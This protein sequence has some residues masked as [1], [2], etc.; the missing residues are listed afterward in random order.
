MDLDYSAD[1]LAFRDEVRDWLSAQPAAGARGQG[2]SLPIAHQ[3]RAACAGTGS[4]PPKDGSRRRGRRNGAAPAGTSC[5]ATFSRRNAATRARRRSR[6]SVS[7]CA[8]RCSSKFGTP[9]QQQRFLPR[10]YRGD[11]F[12][13]QG[14][15]EPGSGS[16][17]ASLRTS[18]VRRGDH[19]IVN[20]QKTWTTLAH[21]ADW[22][23]C[24]VRTGA[25]ADAN[26]QEGISFL[27]IDL[28]HPGH[29][30]A[31]ARP[32]GRGPRGERGL[33]R[34]RRGAGGPARARGRA[35]LDGREV[36]A[37]ARADE[38]R[39][40]RHL[41][42]RAGTPEGVR[43]AAAQGRPA[44]ASTTRAFATGCRGSKSS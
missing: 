30:G 28:A 12:W 39:A 44:A 21:M 6:R 20:G 38:H 7:R 15:S 10:I 32:D 29:H 9:A 1:E 17:L 3:G 16:D 33:L 35:G 13:C 18:A 37:G 25:T 8:R 19:Y 42:A 34:R 14:Y 22:I 23:F 43:R 4:S 31:A 2:R 24:L 27:L 40:H 41:E 11:D 26:K 5:S 36:P